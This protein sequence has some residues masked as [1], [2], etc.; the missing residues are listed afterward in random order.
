MRS[1]CQ[2]GPA[3]LRSLLLLALPV[4]INPVP[5][6][7]PGQAAGQEAGPSGGSVRLGI[8]EAVRYGIDQNKGLAADR[9]QIAAAAGRL[10][11]AGL[12]ANPMLESSGLTGLNDPGMQSVAVGLTL[13]LEVGRRSRRVSLAGHEL[14][15]SRHE[16]A[17]R[18]RMLAADIRLRFAEI[19][20]VREE[21]ALGRRMV[22]LNQEMLRLV[23]ARVTEGVS[24]RLEEN[25][26]LV[27]LR[28][29]EAKVAA[30]ESRLN[31]LTEEFKGQIGLP[32]DAT[33]LMEGQL[34]SSPHGDGANG[35]AHEVVERALRSRP[36]LRA[37]QVAE[38]IGEAMIEMARAEGRFDLSIFGEIGW[39]RW[40]FDQLGR[41]DD[42]FVPVGM[43]TGMI[44]GGVNIMLPTRN[45]NQGGIEAAVAWRDEA[46]LRSE[47]IRSIIRREVQTALEKIEGAQ[48]VLRTFDNNLIE[49]QEKNHQII[50]A[51][52]ELGHARLTDLLAEQRRLVEL[53]MEL[54][55]AR[56][57]L[58]TANIELAR[59]IHQIPGQPPGQTPARR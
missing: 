37:A 51:S 6:Q 12:K 39:Q 52:F 54:T 34:P 42:R 15:R 36:D 27:E 26:Q 16:V 33:L 30:L 38:E 53:R 1:D 40:R 46:R 3:W 17:D 47:F 31:A 23:S 18:E 49:S 57:E 32:I 58:L 2:I 20:A 41:M 43:R 44:R 9:L 56:R 13:P 29:S 5:G 22:E 28:R 21:L 59:A 55:A 4:I 50:R 11:Q 35:A 19:L 45:R 8:E 14:E 10:R 7:V 25:M 48:K 24:A